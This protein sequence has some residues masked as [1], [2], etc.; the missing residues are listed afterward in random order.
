[1]RSRRGLPMIGG[2]G[3]A[4]ALAALTWGVSPARANAID[5]DAVAQCE[6]GGDWTISTGNG[7]SGGLQF[8]PATWAEHGGR[9]DPARA[10]RSDQIRIAERVLRTQGLGAWPVCGPR[11]VDHTGASRAP[12]LIGCE[13][14]PPNVFGLWDLRLLC[15]T[16][17]TTIVAGGG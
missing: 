11:G 9:G 5:W 8:S 17:T 4:L 2:V 3:A 12:R 16:L 6:S 13:A 14:L 10:P 1:M 7:Y 15:Q